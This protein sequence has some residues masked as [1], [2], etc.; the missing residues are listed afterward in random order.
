[1]PGRGGLRVNAWSSKGL[2]CCHV[3]LG[4]ISIARPRQTS[5][6]CRCGRCGS[7]PLVLEHCVLV[8]ILH[9]PLQLSLVR[10]SIER[11]IMAQA[12][13]TRCPTTAVGSMQQR[14]PA[15]ARAC[16]AAARSQSVRWKLTGFAH[17]YTMA[18]LCGQASATLCDQLAAPGCPV[19]CFHISSQK[20]QCLMDGRTHVERSRAW[21]YGAHTCA[22]E[23]HCIT[24]TH[25]VLDNL[26]VCCDCG[27]HHVTMRLQLKW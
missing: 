10:Q 4:Q 18:P 6:C 23:R 11:H 8:S 14:A 3:N 15:P 5:R 21:H 19:G 1:M 16:P 9:T 20:L 13:L 24:P 25:G 2:G 27:R 22:L 17:V 12:M 26:C 7:T